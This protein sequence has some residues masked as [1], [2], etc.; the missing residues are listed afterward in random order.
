[1]CF[2]LHAV[3][4][5]FELVKTPAYLEVMRKRVLIADDSTSVRNVIRSFLRDQEAIEICAKCGWAGRSRKGSE[6][7]TGL[8][9]V[10]SG[11]AGGLT[12]RWWRAS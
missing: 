4:P 10:G 12:V 2:V 11:D 1:M 8:N 5:V 6:S 3:N 7:E 9:S